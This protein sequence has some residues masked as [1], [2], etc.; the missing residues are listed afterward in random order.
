MKVA[1]DRLAYRRPYSRAY[2][3]RTTDEYDFHARP[4]LYWGSRSPQRRLHVYTLFTSISHPS[5]RDRLDTCSRPCR[6]YR[7]ISSFSVKLP[8]GVKYGHRSQKQ[9]NFLAVDKEVVYTI[10]KSGD[11]PRF[12]GRKTTILSVPR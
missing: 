3:M 2:G 10:W 5:R 8:L 12:I 1:A 6:A 4:I 7:Y 9:T 11:L